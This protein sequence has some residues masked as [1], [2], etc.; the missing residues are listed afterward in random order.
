MRRE[1]GVVV[2]IEVRVRA[3]DGRLLTFDEADAEGWMSE[4][5]QADGS[6]MRP[7]YGEV[8]LAVP[9][10][11]YPTWVAREAAILAG[12]TVGGAGVAVAAVRRRRPV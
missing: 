12:L 5:V 10:E 7:G 2:G 4:E 9:G 3:P 6:H 8:A 1:A 11:R